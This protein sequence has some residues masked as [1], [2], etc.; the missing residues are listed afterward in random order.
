MSAAVKEDATRLCRIPQLF[1]STRCNIA[2]LR[3]NPQ[4]NLKNPIRAGNKANKQILGILPGRGDKSDIQIWKNP[5]TRGSGQLSELGIWQIS[6]SNLLLLEQNLCPQH[7]LFFKENSQQFQNFPST[8]ESFLRDLKQKVYKGWQF[9]PKNVC[10]GVKTERSHF[11]KREL[12][13]RL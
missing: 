7:S 5:P 4:T 10:A 9:P 11:S 2:P 8:Y 1:F 13:L 3:A 6:L 12:P